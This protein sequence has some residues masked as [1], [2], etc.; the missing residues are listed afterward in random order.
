MASYSESHRPW[1]HKL[2]KTVNRQVEV[3]QQ[4]I[5]KTIMVLMTVIDLFGLTNELNENYFSKC[6]EKTEKIQ[7][8][9][10]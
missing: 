1:K 4:I 9:K 2:S 6:Q 3:N 10:L 8:Y 7:I 5:E